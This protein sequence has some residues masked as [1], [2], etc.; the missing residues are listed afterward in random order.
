MEKIIDRFDKYM[1]AKGLNDNKVTNKTGVSVGLI[2]KCRKEG[3][4]MSRGLMLQVLQSYDDLSQEWLMLGKGN[5]LITPE[6]DNKEVISELKI[7][8][9][10]EVMELMKMKIVFLED[11]IKNQ[12][13]V[14]ENL[15]YIIEEL[16]A[17]QIDSKI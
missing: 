12:A 4:D 5:M 14:I 13:D 3:R 10:E 17:I 1:S 15:K 11:K 8:G 9:N 16:K 7:K 2:G 6:E